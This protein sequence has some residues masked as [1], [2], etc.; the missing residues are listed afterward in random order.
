MWLLTNSSQSWGIS[1]FA[2][3]EKING[4]PVDVVVFCFGNKTTS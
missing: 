2:I 4:F 3:M 1:G